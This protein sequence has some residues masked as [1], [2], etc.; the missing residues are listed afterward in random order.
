MK[1]NNKKLARDIECIRKSVAAIDELRKS[2]IGESDRGDSV[3]EAQANKATA[4]VLTY[5]VSL[6]GMETK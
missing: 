5:I 6:Y 4:R 3:A 2:F 1:T